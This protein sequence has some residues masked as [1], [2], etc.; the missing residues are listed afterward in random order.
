MTERELIEL[1]LADARRLLDAGEFSAAELAQA[2]I[3]RIEAVDE[4]V[5]AFI[6]RTADLALEM[7]TKADAIISAGESQPMT[8]IPIALKDILCTTNAPTSAGSK[9]LAGYISPYDA[10]VVQKLREQNAVFVGKTNTDEF[11]MGSSTEN[12]AFFTT[13]NPWDLGR[14]PGGSSGGSAAAVAAR[15]AIASLGSDTGGSIRQPAGFCGVVGMKPTYGRV[16]RYG[17]IAFASSLDQIGPFTR[18]VEDNAMVLGAIAG[19]DRRDATSAPVSVPDYLASLKD[20]IKGLRIGVVQEFRDQE[21]IESGV[22]S[23]CEDAYDVLARLGAELS[24]VSLS[25][26]KYALPTYY[27]TAPAEASANLARFD[28]IKYGLSVE[29]DDLMD[30]YL[31][32]RDQGF[33]PEVKRRIMLGTYALA[34]GYYDA[35]YIKAQKV[36][37]LIKRD[38]D[39]AFKDVDVIVAPTSPTVAFNIGDRTDDP[40]Q[41]YLSDIFTIPANMAGL[42][43]IALPNG[44]SEGMPVS[45]Q[46]IGPAFGEEIVLRTAHAYEQATDWHRSTPT[47]LLED[48]AV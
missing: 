35:F 45:M 32:T 21:G 10:T 3:D 11:A 24:P 39:E 18:S 28:G 27:I 25:Y 13:S 4:K 34:A 8:G 33:G 31:K 26:S 7:A 23:A 20:G 41:M 19:H 48:A 44:I 30:V 29:T 47:G 42:P 1:S 9:I 14:V 6:T 46:V 40:L 36:R 37:T 22:A 16:S 17:L 15:E 43:G 5:N 2:H 12:S 38:F